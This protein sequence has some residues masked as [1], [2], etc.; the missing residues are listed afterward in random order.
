MLQLFLT[1]L[2]CSYA[3]DEHKSIPDVIEFEPPTTPKNVAKARQILGYDIYDRE[4][5]NNRGRKVIYGNNWE[6]YA[7]NLPE[8]SF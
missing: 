2:T 3:T 5:V 1:L 8:I 6:Q 4:P 7:D